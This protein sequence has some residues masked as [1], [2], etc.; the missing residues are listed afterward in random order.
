MEVM[1]ARFWYTII[2]VMPTKQVNDNMFNLAAV[3]VYHYANTMQ[4]VSAVVF[5]AMLAKWPET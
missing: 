3:G 4:L 5:N 2:V 1:F